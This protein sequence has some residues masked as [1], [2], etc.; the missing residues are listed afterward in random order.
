MVKKQKKNFVIAEPYCRFWVCNG[1]ILKDIKE[2]AGELKTIDEKSFKHHVSKTKNDFV[3]W[4][5][6]VMR[7]P[8]LA[9]KI[10]RTKTRASMLKAVQ[11]HIKSSYQN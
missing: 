6:D 8:E 9:K 7:D 5:N 3:A 2:M 1:A 10:S 11:S 4:V